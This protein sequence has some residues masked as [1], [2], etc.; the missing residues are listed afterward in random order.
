MAGWKILHLLDNVLIGTLLF[1]S[2]SIGL[3]SLS[4]SLI[5]YKCFLSQP[6]LVSGLAYTTTSFQLPRISKDHIGLGHG[7]DGT[8]RFRAI[9][10]AD[11]YLMDVANV[12]SKN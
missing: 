12:G 8:L 4:L 9:V 7:L 10:G 1:I 3:C 5:T 6:C 11:G 2:I